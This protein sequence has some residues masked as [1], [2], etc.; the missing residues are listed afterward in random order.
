MSRA[1]LQPTSDEID[2]VIGA[3]RDNLGVYTRL[4]WPRWKRGKHIEEIYKV[5]HRVERGELD[6]VI[7]L[8]PPRHSKSM[9]VSEFFPAWYLGKHP[10]RYIIGASYGQALAQGFGLRVRNMIRDPIHTQI[11]PESCLSSD[12][13]AKD[14]FGLTA[15]GQYFA[16]GRGSATTGRGAHVFIVDDPVSD[17][18]EATSEALRQQLHE[19]FSTVAYT[20]LQPENTIIICQTLW[21]EDDLAGWLMREHM[22]DGWV[23]VKMPAIAKE[24]TV[25]SDGLPW[26][27]KGDALWPEMWPVDK[28]ERAQ[29]MQTTEDWE[30]LYQQECVSDEGNCFKVS[31]LG[32]CKDEMRDESNPFVGNGLTKYIVVD[33]ASSKKK[34]SDYTSMWVLG[35]GADECIYVLDMIRDKLTTPSQRWDALYGLHRKHKPIS[36]VFYEEYGHKA[37]VA[38]IREKQSDKNYWFA[39]TPVGGTLGKIERIKQLEPFFRDGRMRMPYR[40]LGMTEGREVDLMKSFAEEYK[41]FPKGA[42]DDML[43]SLARIRT[44]GIT[45]D[46][47]ATA[48]A[49]AMEEMLHPEREHEQGSWLSA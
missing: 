12:S 28:L 33:P 11:F 7:F 49:A 3:A 10:D 48:D 40:W 13:S 8:L 41:S 15:G 47:P 42:H 26:R 35:L 24:D 46:W 44:P 18:V 6:R 38:Y 37:D 25:D 23:V 19:W 17:K 4:Q 5:L 16:V 31:W 9:S 14:H 2:Q 27:K 34:G 39:V 21:N 22:D 20:R 1:I 45:L 30:S 29:R 36:R 32:L 43:D